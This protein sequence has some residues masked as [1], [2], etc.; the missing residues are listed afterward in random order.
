ME[1]HKSP[2]IEE[3]KNYYKE[4]I[5]KIKNKLL[6]AYILKNEKLRDIL[7]AKEIENFDKIKNENQQVQNL[8]DY[9]VSNIIDRIVNEIYRQIATNNYSFD[10]FSL[11]TT[12]SDFFP[13]FSIF[14][15]FFLVY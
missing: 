2:K 11:Y 6:N 12:K 10:D 14:F 8:N 1:K 4:D 7:F 5:E 9:I 15:F 3:I 13:L